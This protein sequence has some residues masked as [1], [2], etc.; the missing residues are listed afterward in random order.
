MNIIQAI[1]DEQ[2]FR[3]FLADRSGSLRSW[4][5]WMSALRAVYGLGIRKPKNIELVT[6]CTGRTQLPAK[7]FSQA[8]F[9]TGRRSG[10]SRIAAIIGAYEAALSGKEK[11]LAAGELGMVAIIAPTRKQARIVKNYLRSIFDQTELL[12]QEVVKT[13]QEGFE[14]RNGVLIEIQV[15]DWRAVRGYS[16]IACII[17]ELAFMGLDEESKVKSDTRVDPCG[18]SESGFVWWKTGLHFESICTKGLVLAAI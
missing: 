8:L 17:D 3:P 2:L 5:N 11:L 13:T 1:R 16:L 4:H 6:A 15:G 12:R 7:G 10:K 18:A 14:L 9:L